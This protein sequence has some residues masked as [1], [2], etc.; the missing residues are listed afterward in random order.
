MQSQE[1]E[2]GLVQVLGGRGAWFPGVISMIS[3]MSP[4]SDSAL[5]IKNER[6]HQVSTKHGAALLLRIR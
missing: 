2:K 1:I 4:A 5:D 3:L 6:Y